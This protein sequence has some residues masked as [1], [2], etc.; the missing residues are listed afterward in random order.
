MIYKYSASGAPSA[1][2][3]L[4]VRSA[5]SASGALSVR[6]AFSVRSAPSKGKAN[7]SA[8][9]LPGFC[10]VRLSDWQ[11]GLLFQPA[12]RHLC[13]LRLLAVGYSQVPGEGEGEEYR[14]DVP[15]FVRSGREEV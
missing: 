15:G 12:R 8:I 4:S 6:I 14:C 7:I 13:P 9:I 5:L 1:S 10:R 2:G 3:A 11:Q